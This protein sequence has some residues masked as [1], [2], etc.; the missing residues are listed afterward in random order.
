M[1]AKENRLTSKELKD[2]GRFSLQRG[3][4]IDIKR[5]ENF[6]KK[7]SCILSA[8]TF[9]KAVDRNK[10]KRLVYGI[11]Q[12]GLISQGKKNKERSALL[13]PKKN[14]LE[15]DREIIKKEILSNL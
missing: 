5:L 4:C 11:L 1:L 6:E 12:E 14:I 2:V 8:K 3:K 15:I 9:K 10:V 13:Y 7:Y